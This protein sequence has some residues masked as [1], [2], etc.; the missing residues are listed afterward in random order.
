MEVGLPE[1]RTR[2]RFQVGHCQES[3]EPRRSPRSPGR[4]QTGLQP[5]SLPGGEA[6]RPAMPSLPARARQPELHVHAHPRALGARWF[7]VLGPAC[8]ATESCRKSP[9]FMK[10]A[11]CFPPSLHLGRPSPPEALAQM[12]PVEGRLSRP[13]WPRWQTSCPPG[14]TPGPFGGTRHP[15]MDH[16]PCSRICL[17]VSS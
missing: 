2:K 11:R 14:P 5:G 1:G 15:L 4:R 16:I 7:P 3:P 8:G 10:Y 9:V 12:S 13:P 17:F 6:C